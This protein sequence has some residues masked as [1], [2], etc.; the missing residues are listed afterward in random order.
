M[1]AV[2]AGTRRGGGRVKSGKAMP[3]A[4]D[5]GKEFFM[6]ALVRHGDYG[7]ELNEVYEWD[8]IHGQELTVEGVH[9]ILV[10]EVGWRE[11]RN[12]AQHEDAT[13]VKRMHGGGC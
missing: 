7:E 6:N 5:R 1:A 2:M 10:Y 9:E 3:V 11:H 12:Q 13:E 4:A 8:R